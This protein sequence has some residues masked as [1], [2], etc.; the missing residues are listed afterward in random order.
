MIV[1]IT[2]S[3]SLYKFEFPQVDPLFQCFDIETKEEK[4]RKKSEKKNIVNKSK[5]ELNNQ[6]CFDHNKMMCWKRKKDAPS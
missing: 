4:R 3:N 5:I 6:E 2:I 1:I